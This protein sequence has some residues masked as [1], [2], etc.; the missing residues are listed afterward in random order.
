MHTCCSLV[1]KENLTKFQK[2]TILASTSF[3]PE[4]HDS[5]RNK[6]LALGT[7]EQAAEILAAGG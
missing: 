7:A 2:S 6:Y 5:L 3:C 1:F 4:G